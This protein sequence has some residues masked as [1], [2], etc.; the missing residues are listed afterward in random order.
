MV[1]KLKP[2]QRVRVE[3]RWRDGDEEK[4]WFVMLT[5]EI[6]RAELRDG[7]APML[8]HTLKMVQR[9]M[10]VALYRGREFAMLEGIPEER[11]P[12]VVDFG[13]VEE[14]DNG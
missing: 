9:Q 5:D 8:S 1:D 14:S 6:F 4:S 11:G 2:G 7:P 10:Y 3:I 12:D 13:P